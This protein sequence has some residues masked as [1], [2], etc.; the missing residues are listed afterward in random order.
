MTGLSVVARD[1]ALVACAALAGCSPATIDVVELAPGALF[2]GL[3]A[4]W[5]FDDG[6]GKTLTDSTT[7]KRDGIVFPGAI[8]QTADAGHPGF[9]GFLHFYGSAMSEVD[10]PGFPQPTASWSVAGWIRAPDQ[11][12]AVGDGYVTI[13][14]T[15][16]PH[17]ATGPMA[18]GWELN[19][20]IG[21]PSNPTNNVSLYQYAY[22]KGPLDNSYSYQECKCFVAGEWAHIAGVYNADQQTISI[23]HNGSL[24][25]S[26]APEPNILRGTDILYFGRWSFDATS[27]RLIGDLDDFV[28]YNR[29]L[30]PPEVRQLASAP[31]PAMPPP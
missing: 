29:T 23:Y 1:A 2:E 15:E 7:N 18:G 19:L 24:V 30:T 16:I 28:I 22:W 17:T 14:S 20:R 21:M 26:D 12:Q 31:L 9:G 27:R 13:V 10:V 8:F 4:H 25:G 6:A 5:T 3:I 11:N